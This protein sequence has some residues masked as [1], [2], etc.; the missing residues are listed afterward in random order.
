MV[1]VMYLRST[2]DHYPDYQNDKIGL[3]EYVLMVHTWI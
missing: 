1:N 2:I 3:F